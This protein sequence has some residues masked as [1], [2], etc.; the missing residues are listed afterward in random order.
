MLL[1]A[2]ISQVPADGLRF[3]EWQAAMQVWVWLAIAARQSVQPGPRRASLQALGFR[4]L[5][6]V[7][8]I[9]RQ[10]PQ[11]ASLGKNHRG[12]LP[13]CMLLQQCMALQPPE[14]ACRPASELESVLR[15]TDAAARLLPVFL[16]RVPAGGGQMPQPPPRQ[17]TPQQ[18]Q[19]QRLNSPG[20]CERHVCADAAAACLEAA[21][22][23]C[24]AAMSFM[25]SNPFGRIPPQQ[26][27]PVAAAAQQFAATCCRLLHYGLGCTAEQRAMLPELGDPL[28]LHSRAVHAVTVHRD[29]VREIA[30]RLPDVAQWQA[31][32]R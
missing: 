26:L 11:E 12:A 27:A 20:G 8:P 7:A 14:A 19:Q 9:V 24:V 32:M 30:E 31:A 3:T 16:A 29:L 21:R 25:G 4:L 6:R 28:W 2:A 5:H 23:G 17:P 13:C 1:P 22:F 15:G 18:P 10:E